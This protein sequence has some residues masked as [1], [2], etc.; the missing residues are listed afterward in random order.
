MNVTKF[1]LLHVIIRSVSQLL[2]S[3]TKLYDI[4]QH[5]SVQLLQISILI[6]TKSEKHNFVNLWECIESWQIV[7]VIERSVVICKMPS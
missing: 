4:P 3:G 1:Y 6:C 2:I 5:A 7:S